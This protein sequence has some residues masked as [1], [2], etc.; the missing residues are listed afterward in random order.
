MAST[1]FL[2]SSVTGPW[3]IGSSSSSSSSGRSAMAV[4]APAT[5]TAGLTVPERPPAAVAAATGC[6]C[7]AGW[8]ARLAPGGLG[9]GDRAL[10]DLARPLGRAAGPFSESLDLPRLGE[11]QQ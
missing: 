9:L 10:L 2:P 5:G 11:V 8:T 4:A 6:A 1:G 7:A 3:T